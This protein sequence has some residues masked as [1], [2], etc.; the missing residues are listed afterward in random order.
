MISECLIRS[1]MLYLYHLRT[2]QQIFIVCQPC[3]QYRVNQKI[4]NKY[5][6]Q[7]LTLR[8]IIFSERPIGVWLYVAKRQRQ[9]QIRS[10]GIERTEGQGVSEKKGLKT[11]LRRTQDLNRK[12]E[13][14]GA[15][16]PYQ[17]PLLTK[18]RLQRGCIGI[19]RTPEHCLENTTLPFQ[20]LPTK[21]KYLGS[22]FEPIGRAV[23]Q[24]FCNTLTYTLLFLWVL[25]LLLQSSILTLKIN[26]QCEQQQK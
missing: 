4:Q 23:F 13:G 11:C 9:V 10:F 25:F 18:S 6:A 14:E 26:L 22:A 5:N 2:I 21:C 7:P 16:F 19:V 15:Q 17:L 12:S 1:K 20:Q 3:I 8:N 24:G